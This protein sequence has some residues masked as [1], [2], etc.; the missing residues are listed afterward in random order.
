MTSLTIRKIL[1]AT[2]FLESSRLA[3]DYAVAMAHHF[4][5]EILML[6]ATELPA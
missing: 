1:F 3:L 5:G 2:D 4:G 6:H